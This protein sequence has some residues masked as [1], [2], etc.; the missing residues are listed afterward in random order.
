MSKLLASGFASAIALAGVVFTAAPRTPESATVTMWTEP[1]PVSPVAG[2]PAEALP[3]AG[4]CRIWYDALPADKQP[5][6]MECEHADWLARSWGGR[7]IS[8]EAE[9][10][11]YQG[12]NDFS[13]VPASALPRPGWCRAWV[14]G[15]AADAQPEA[16]DC[17]VA[18]RIAS[19]LGGRVLFMPL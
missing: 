16:S 7:V 18:R 13:G 2:V 9:R 17:V 4:E 19:E 5:A 10:A 14:E 3:R 6:S 1:A 12:R 15:V 11:A 8:R